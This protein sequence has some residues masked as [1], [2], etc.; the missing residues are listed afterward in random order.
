MRR[1]VTALTFVA[2]AL[3]GACSGGDEDSAGN[4]QTASRPAGGQPAPGMAFD[5]LEDDA[6]SSS[7]AGSGGSSVAIP[8]IGPAIIKTAEVTLE[9]P[10]KGLGGAI[11]EATALA[12]SNGGHVVTTAIDQEG[13]RRGTLIL[14]VPADRFEEA[15]GD[16]ESL[17]D[18]SK[19]AITGDDV[20][21]EVVDLEARLRNL[22][23]Q[24]TVLLR[25]MDR[26]QTVS[27]TIKVQRHLQGVQLDVERIRGRLA[28][29]ENQASLSTITARFVAAGPVPG[30]P[31]TLA[32]A[33]QR[34][35]EVATNVVSG[36]IIATGFIVPVG[37]LLV[38]ALLVARRLLPKFG[39]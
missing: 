39:S 15:L 25:L 29:L 34:A 23:A 33:W 14:R 30:D 8:G 27:D 19:K 6:I 20:S 31:G 32:R 24:E 28:Y 1:K 17:G 21:L 11:T 37:L 7:S 9:V 36:L 2:I 3:L 26:S 35:L 38:L 16:L 5:A 18:V 13:T 22:R 12:A 10:A 4:A